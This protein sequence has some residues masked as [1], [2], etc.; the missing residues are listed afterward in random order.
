[1]PETT[2]HNAAPSRDLGVLPDSV[3]RDPRASAYLTF[4][5]LPDGVD[6]ASMKTWLA[7][8]AQ[9]ID[10][11]ESHQGRDEPYASAVF[12][13]GP[14]FFTRFPQYQANNPANLNFKLDLPAPMPPVDAFIY[15][16]STS[17]QRVADFL[18]GLWCGHPATLTSV[19]VERGYQRTD[20]REA[21]GN[22]DGLRRPAPDQRAAV[23]LIDRIVFPEEPAWLDGGSYA[24]YMKIEQLLAQWQTLD[25]AA[26]ENVIGRR[27]PDG[28]RLDL[29]VGTN[30]LAEPEYTSPTCPIATAHARKAGPRG[31]INDQNQI[32]RR[33]VPYV[34]ATDGAVH[35][36]LQFVSFQAT[37]AYFDVVFNHWMLNKEFPTA[38]TG[39]DELVRQNL[40]SFLKSGLFVIPP[41][42]VQ[43]PAAGYFE[44]TSPPPAKGKTGKIHIRKQVL[45]PGGN[46]A[47]AEMGGIPIGIFDATS[48]Q[49][50]GDTVITN[51]A[52]NAV[53]DDIPL[54]T[55]VLVR[56]LLAGDTRFEPPTD[57]PVTVTVE[58]QVVQII[59]RLKATAP[60][61]G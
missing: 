44:I 14:K 6:E 43:F 59:N 24:V 60:V 38:G 56:E 10:V 21:F 11:L 45:D 51:P 5:T 25:Q 61:Y 22:L 52:G 19:E 23:A 47:R 16:M 31:S 55:A 46:P 12:G 36:G 8:I 9:R 20:K 53:T 40:L 58:N 4:I 15:I 39:A 35:A 57:V 29:P 7:D 54:G 41:I 32:F 50:I 42:D 33:G 3:I 2:A 37:P 13:L 1:M 27:H 49:Q 30:P 34:E 18:T 28:S 48:G 17:E 26:Q